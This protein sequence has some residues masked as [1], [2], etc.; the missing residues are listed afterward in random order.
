MATEALDKVKAQFELDNGRL[1]IITP[2]RYEETYDIMGN[3]FVPDEPLS[4][5]FGVTWH[6]DFETLTHDQL[7]QNLSICMI[8]KDTRE[9]MGVRLIGLMKKSDPHNYFSNIKYEPLRSLYEFLTHKD[10]E[11]NFF[12]RY[13]VDEAVHFFT[14][15]VHKKY[16]RMG[17]G[18]RLLAAAVAMSRELGFKA[19]K[20]E[21]TSN[22][23]Q[24]IYEKQGFET[25]LE[26]P[27]DNYFY[28]GKPIRDGTGEHT[29]TKIYGLK[30]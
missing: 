14:L 6:D 3:H 8:D 20:G 22:F 30:L 15:G 12:E 19:I 29:M 23:S 4:R 27:Y 25:L 24:R 26:M 2:D 10:K 9:I 21:G 5:A 1:A 11:I 13:G 7:V 16:R 18:G 17:L 28:K